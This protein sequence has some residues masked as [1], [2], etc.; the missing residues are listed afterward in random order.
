[1]LNMLFCQ[2]DVLMTHVLSVGVVE[3][4]LVM[5]NSGDSRGTMTWD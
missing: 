3:T 5:L 4:S 1:M 2:Q